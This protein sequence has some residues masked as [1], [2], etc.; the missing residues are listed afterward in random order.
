M[1]ESCG[2]DT[3]AIASCFV[4]QK[5]GFAIY[6]DYCTNYPKYASGCHVYVISIAF[7]VVKKI[8]IVT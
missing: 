1:L 2:K 4:S 8:L 3:V 6:S 7:T 5:E